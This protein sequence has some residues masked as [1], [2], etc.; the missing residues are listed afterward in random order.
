MERLFNVGWKLGQKWS[1]LL[2]VRVLCCLFNNKMFSD[3][4]RQGWDTPEPPNS[5]RAWLMTSLERCDV[6]TSSFS[7]VRDITTSGCRHSATL[8]CATTLSNYY[9]DEE[10]NHFVSTEIRW[11]KLYRPVNVLLDAIIP[12]RPRAE[13]VQITL[14]DGLNI[15]LVYL[16]TGAERAANSGITGH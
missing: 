12:R 9:D 11:D 1:I 3:S 7:D 15:L 16:F 6:K 5:P 10:K 8:G 4:I 13:R 2:G 14:E